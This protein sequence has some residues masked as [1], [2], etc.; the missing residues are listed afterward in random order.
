MRHVRHFIGGQWA[1]SADGATFESISPI[2]NT[3]IASVARGGA[4][5]RTARWP[6]RAARSTRGRGHG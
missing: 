5:T 4:P 1:D 6:R 2:D 3:V